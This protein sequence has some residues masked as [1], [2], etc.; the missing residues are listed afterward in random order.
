MKNFDR[1]DFISLIIKNR[2]STRSFTDEKISKTN[3]LKLID[4]AIYAPTG[5][6]SQNIKF[7]IID[8]PEE[9]K[10]IGMARFSWP[11]SNAAKMKEKYPSGLIGNS[12]CAIFVF[13]D[14]K[15]RNYNDDH[16]LG[17]YFIWKNLEKENAS[18]AIQNILL[19][20]TALGI[21]SCWIS[22]NE[23]MNYTR[24]M[25]GTSFYETFSNYGVPQHF[26][27]QGCVILGYPRLGYYE[28]FPR[29]EKKHGPNLANVERSKIEDYLIIS[30][31]D[32]NLK[33]S[34]IKNLAYPIF[35]IILG[36]A[37]HI[38]LFLV[39]IL[40]RFKCKIE[41]KFF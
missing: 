17:E 9:L 16:N 32:Q 24:L 36:K 22:L 31:V 4:A 11:Y 38:L 14:T 29:G 8:S 33:K 6:N 3:I 15:K 40:D 10:K 30:N 25:S 37:I 39:R 20:A 41:K 21:G 13:S 1:Y 12:T 7:L 28:K 2:R 18:A 35:N 5:T 23:E 27:P 19:A 34:K 26:I